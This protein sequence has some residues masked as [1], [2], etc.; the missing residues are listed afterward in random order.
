VNK[1]KLLAYALAAWLVVEVVAF[2]LVVQFLGLIAAV[3]LGLGT[4][5]LG[6]LD[7]RRLFDYMRARA[8]GRKVAPKDAGAESAKSKNAPLIDGGLQALGALLLIL[9]GFAS[10]LVG[11]ALKAPS[12]RAGLAERIRN[13]GPKRKGP[14]TIDLSPTE[15]KALHHRPQKRRRRAPAAQGS[16][17]P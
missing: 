13:G 7:V 6:L 3:A 15:W 11:L 14:A 5:L 16:Q 12:I 17:T 2:V 10:D 4:T 1:S 8:G 9:P